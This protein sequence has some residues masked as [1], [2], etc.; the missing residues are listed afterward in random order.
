MKI[1]F[2]RKLLL[3]VLLLAAE[4]VFAETGERP[5]EPGLKSPPATISADPGDLQ[6]GKPEKRPDKASIWNSRQR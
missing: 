1:D 6:P 4:M 2:A 5:P 3:I